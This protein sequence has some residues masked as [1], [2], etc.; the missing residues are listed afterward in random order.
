MIVYAFVLFLILFFGLRYLKVFRVDGLS[1]WT[2]PLAFTAKIIF[3]GLFLYLYTYI[4]GDGSLSEDAGVFM[5]ESKM[6]RDVFS[7]SPEAYFKLM[8]SI[9]ENQNLIQQYLPETTHWDVGIQ[10]IVNDNKNILRAHSLIQFFSFNYAPI[11]MLIS[12]FI[13]LLGIR[14][15]VE[16]LKSMTQIELKYVF[17]GIFLLPSLLF[18]TSGILKEPFMLFGLGLLLRGVFS[19][20]S[21]PKKWLFVLSGVLLLLGFKLYVLFAILPALLFLAIAKWLPKYNIAG[22]L[23]ILAF[24]FGMLLLIFPGKREV[25]IQT[26][27]RKQ[28]DFINVA[29]GGIHVYADTL[30][31]YFEPE[32]VGLLRIEN[33]SVS[34]KNDIDAKILKLGQIDR[35]RDVHFVADGSKWP[36]YFENDRSNGFIE[37]TLIDNSYGQLIKN[38][39]EALSNAL[40]R[41]LPNDPGSKLKYVAF[42]ETLLVFGFLGFAIYRRRTI[43]EIERRR[44]VALVIFAVFLA[45]FIGWTTPVVG[46][47]ARYRIPV[48]LAIIIIGGILMEVKIE[49]SKLKIRNS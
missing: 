1:V 48:Y 36:I 46:A 25:A 38:I 35:P 29:K 19:E 16:A 9:G 10:S 15:L 23:A 21:L 41:P 34:L 45:L 13:A 39:P 47:I 22:A 11:H 30:F 40:F 20:L 2:M 28:F 43:N 7:Q 14:H 8:T 32:Q 6:L 12:C 4:L 3:G 44:I 49:N 33:D 18:W 42:L 5:R 37:L 31:Y 27:S 17:W 24:T 26:I